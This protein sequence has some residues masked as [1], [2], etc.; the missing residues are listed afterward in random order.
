MEGPQGRS[1]LSRA[2]KDKYELGQMWRRDKSIPDWGNHV[3]KGP[4]VRK[5]LVGRWLLEV[6]GAVCEDFSVAGVQNMAREEEVMRTW[7]GAS[8]GPDRPQGA[9]AGR[10]KVRVTSLPNGSRGSLAQRCLLPPLLH[11]NTHTVPSQR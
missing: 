11:G 1:Q 5:V 4:E 2:L 9:L 10:G 3:H 7:Q 8:C 6:R